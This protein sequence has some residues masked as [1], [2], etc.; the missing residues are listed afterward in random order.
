MDI[1]SRLTEKAMLQVRPLSDPTGLLPLCMVSKHSTHTRASFSRYFSLHFLLQQTA[2]K[3][4]QKCRKK[5]TRIK[6]KRLTIKK[7]GKT[8]HYFRLVF[9]LAP[10]FGRTAQQGRN[11]SWKIEM[12]TR[13]LCICEFRKL[14]LPVCSFALLKIPLS[15]SPKFHWAYCNSN[16]K[17][18]YVRERC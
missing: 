14:N 17:C 2:Q 7:P 3:T 18:G 15:C 10:T 13:P 8:L 9:V 5:K 16:Q 11:R 1:L 12:L 4:C 6:K